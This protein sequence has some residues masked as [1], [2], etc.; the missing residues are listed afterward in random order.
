MKRRSR[1]AGVSFAHQGLALSLIEIW[2][3]ETELRSSSC[4]QIARGSRR[5]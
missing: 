4:F 2:I 5:S 1:E 3:D